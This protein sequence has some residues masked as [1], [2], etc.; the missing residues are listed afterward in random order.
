MEDNDTFVASTCKVQHLFEERNMKTLSK[1]LFNCQHLQKGLLPL[2]L[3]LALSI[4][5]TNAMA[6]K[7]PFAQFVGKPYASYHYALRDSMRIRYKKGSVAL[8][9]LTIKQM[10]SLPDKFHDGQWQI[11]SDYFFANFLYRWK[12]ESRELFVPRMNKVLEES[13]KYKNVIWQIRILRRL[14]DL[15][16]DDSLVIAIHYARE[17]ENLLPKVTI[18][19]Y[20]DVVDCK[21][22]LGETYMKYHDYLRAEKYYKEVVASPVFAKNQRIF[23]LARNDLG[24]L[25]RNYYHNLNKSDMWFKSILSFDKRYSINEIRMHRIATALGELGRNDFLRGRYASSERLLLQSLG[26]MSK[27]KNEDNDDDHTTYY[28]M[29]CTLAECYCEMK[30]YG[31]ALVYI[32]KADSCN[33]FVT[34]PTSQQN[35]FIAKSKYYMGINKT[36]MAYAYLDSAFKA[37]DEW[38][39]HHNMNLFFEI[40]NQV[41]QYEL[42]QKDMQI[43]STYAKF[44]ITLILFIAIT[45]VLI[46]HFMFYLQK[47]KAYRALVLKNQQWAE[48]NKPYLIISA[49]KNK[50]QTEA[51]DKLYKYVEDYIESSQCYCDAD[52]TLDSLS[53]ELGINRTYLSNAINK[54]NDNFKSLI[55]RYRIRLAIRLLSENNSRTMEDIAYSTGFNNR[56][57]FYNAFLSIAGLSPSQFKRNIQRTEK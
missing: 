13:K 8:M 22:H 31:K 47:R 33:K 1:K 17:M 43:Q 35:I 38:D 28:R 39:L 45:I 50:S 30:E 41:G 5:C 56:K 57:S 12:M 42:Q 44:I 26:I 9:Q 20:P 53:K 7:N 14:F 15:Y 4:D 40:E 32:N 37:R 51:D 27:E 10:K 19:E 46:L 6:Q 36:S 29:A 48:D 16:K 25:E 11:E 3:L 24:L 54:T 52:L 2:F 55:N 49:L 23:I 18:K 34:P 21:Y